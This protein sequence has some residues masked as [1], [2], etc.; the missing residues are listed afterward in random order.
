[1]RK[2]HVGQDEYIYRLYSIALVAIVLAT[3]FNGEI[4]RGLY[5][6]SVP[7]TLDEI[8]SGKMPT[9][10]CREKLFVIMMFGTTGFFG[11]SAAAA[12]T[13]H[14]G[15]LPMSLTS[16]ARKATTLFLSFALFGNECSIEHIIGIFVFVSALLMKAIGKTRI[17]IDGILPFVVPTRSGNNSSILMVK[18]DGTETSRSIP[19]TV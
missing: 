9:W 11:S 1:M 17:G 4:S 19:S 12:I 18:L 10:S 2:Y 16:V 14:F 5:F 15:A 7:G 13:K 6:L 8:E 3:E